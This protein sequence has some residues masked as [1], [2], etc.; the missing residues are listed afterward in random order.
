MKIQISLRPPDTPKLPKVSPTPEII[1]FSCNNVDS[2]ITK[3][4]SDEILNDRNQFYRNLMPY[5]FVG[6]RTKGYRRG[7]TNDEDTGE[8]AER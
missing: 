7:R 5:N 3:F 2:Y 1:M 6:R 8:R 4:H